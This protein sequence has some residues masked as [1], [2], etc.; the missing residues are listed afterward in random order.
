MNNN[1]STM[2]G[3]YHILPQ[4]AYV[5]ACARAVHRCQPNPPVYWRRVI[6][7]FHLS[8][9]LSVDSRQILPLD[10]ISTPIWANGRLTF[11]SS[12]M[13]GLKLAI[14]FASSS[15]RLAYSFGTGIYANIVPPLTHDVLQHIKLSDTIRIFSQHGQI[16]LSR[17]TR[18]YDESEL[19]LA[20]WILNGPWR[21]SGRSQTPHG[22][23]WRS[24]QCIHS[25]SGNGE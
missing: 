22:C 20:E 2:S 21:I 6:K 15:V 13:I 19:H 3:M 10:Q 11:P 25:C 7:S 9:I 17:C 14:L 23:M 18:P 5:W 1:C 4:R 16:C 24:R 8:F 12:G